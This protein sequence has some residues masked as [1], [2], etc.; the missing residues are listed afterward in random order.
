[1]GQMGGMGGGGFMAL[2]GDQALGRR[3]NNNVQMHTWY[4]SFPLHRQDCQIPNFTPKIPKIYPK[5]SKTCSFLRS[6]WKIL[7]LTELFYTGTA[8]VPVTNMCVTAFFCIIIIIWEW[9]CGK[10]RVILHSFSSEIVWCIFN[11]TLMRSAL[12]TPSS[13]SA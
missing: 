8:V 5:N 2:L 10:L 1:M 4:L 7:H 9:E 3:T 13:S 11:H 12:L 6:I